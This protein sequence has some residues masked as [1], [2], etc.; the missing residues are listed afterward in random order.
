MISINY[1]VHLF[2]PFCMW[3][4]WSSFLILGQVGHVLRE[5]GAGEAAPGGGGGGGGEVGCGHGG[6]GEGEGEERR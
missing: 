3:L 1:I 6:E 2:L 4:P 5:G